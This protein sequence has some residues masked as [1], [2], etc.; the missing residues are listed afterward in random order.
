M[1]FKIEKQAMVFRLDMDGF[2]LD[3]GQFFC[4]I[5]VVLQGYG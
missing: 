1:F 5:L 2:S 4:W 3:N